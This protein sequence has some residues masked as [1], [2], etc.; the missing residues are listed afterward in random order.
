MRRVYKYSV[1]MAIPDRSRGERVNVGILVYKQGELDVR[2]PEAGKIE[3]LTGRD[4]N[5]Y[6]GKV[7][8][9]L[10]DTYLSSGESMID[11]VAQNPRID[12]AFELSR[13]GAFLIFNDRD[14]EPRVN[15]ILNTLVITPKIIERRASVTRIN[16]EISKLLGR[17]GLLGKNEEQLE[18]HKVFRDREVE[19]GLKADFVQKNGVMRITATL[20]LRRQTNSM[21]EAALKAITL[22]RAKYHYGDD[23]I[24]VGVYAVEDASVPNVRAQLQIME[25]YSTQMFNWQ[26]QS[27]Q[28]RLG[29][30]FKSGL[31]REGGLSL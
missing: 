18:T 17:L 7:V 21:K 4:W 2:V 28:K 11:N 30:F 27:E 23:S 12:P 19:D 10:K 29:D 16:T 22:D 9:N 15:E 25:E 31:I 6:L 20:D 8:A 3:A 1:L 5:S 26:N 13:G 24:R 14:Y